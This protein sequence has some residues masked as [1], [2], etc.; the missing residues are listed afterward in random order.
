MDTLKSFLLAVKENETRLRDLELSFADDQL[1][2]Q[3]Q[4]QLNELNQKREKLRIELSRLREEHLAKNRDEINFLKE[5]I[6]YL[7]NLVFH[8]DGLEPKNYS[9][10]IQTMF[11]RFKSG[12]TTSLSMK[13]LVWVSNDERYIVLKVKGHGGG[14]YPNNWYLPVSFY[15]YSVEHA[16]LHDLTIGLGSILSFEGRRW[17]RRMLKQFQVAIQKYECNLK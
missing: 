4:K 10:D 16:N 2:I 15:L 13:R 3:Y 1:Y 8:A 11:K 5:E 6:S 12:T 7:K 17:S 14:S 9:Y